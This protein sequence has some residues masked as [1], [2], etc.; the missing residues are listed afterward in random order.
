MST[1][2]KIMILNEINDVNYF[3]T[4]VYNSTALEKKYF[5][6]YQ[7]N[8]MNNFGT[9]FIEEKMVKNSGIL[10]GCEKKHF[11]KKKFCKKIKKRF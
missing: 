8:P 9:K 2:G 10:S 5:Y 11:T 6:I 1:W 3:K 7:K 4:S